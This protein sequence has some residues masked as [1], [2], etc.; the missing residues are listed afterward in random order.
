MTV[1]ARALF[2]LGALALTCNLAPA[3]GY[4]AEIAVTTTADELNADG[5]CSLREAIQAANTDTAVDACPAGSGAD[6]IVVPAGTYAISIAGTGEDAN[7]TG[8]FDITSASA[9]YPICCA[10]PRVGT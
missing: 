6:T 7:A 10:G 4:A 3:A 5:D 9:R 1:L 8:D 2:S